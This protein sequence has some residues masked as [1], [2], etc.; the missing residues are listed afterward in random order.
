MRSGALRGF[1]GSGEE[2]LGDWRGASTSRFSI[3][4]VSAFY[5]VMEGA[6]IDAL[7]DVLILTRLQRLMARVSARLYSDK[8][9][10]YFSKGKS[11]RG[12][13][14]FKGYAHGVFACSNIV[15]W[16]LL[17]RLSLQ[18]AFRDE[19]W[20]HSSRVKISQRQSH[21]IPESLERHR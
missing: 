11:S 21:H 4:V 20:P 2:A 14:R 5:N 13:R 19:P 3:V 15:I 8:A 1:R 17:H 9:S 16:V 18:Y 12:T 6:G 10:M 7:G